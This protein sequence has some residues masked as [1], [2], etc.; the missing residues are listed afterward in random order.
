MSAKR[1]NIQASCSE[2]ICT[3]S[4]HTEL[5]ATL[6]DFLFPG[7]SLLLIQLVKIIELSERL[8]MSVGKRKGYGNP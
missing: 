2:L 5:L 6:Q 1:S 3:I 8:I 4:S 7:L